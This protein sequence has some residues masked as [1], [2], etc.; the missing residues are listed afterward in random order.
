MTAVTPSEVSRS[1]AAAAA[2]G[3]AAAA[4]AETSALPRYFT[5]GFAL[6]LVVLEVAWLGVIAYGLWILVGSVWRT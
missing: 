1:Q 4:E 2:D 3:R 5:V 6:L